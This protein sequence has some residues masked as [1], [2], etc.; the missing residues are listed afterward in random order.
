MKIH[1]ALKET[2]YLTDGLS[3]TGFAAIATTIGNYLLATNPGW[4]GRIPCP[5]ASPARPTRAGGTT[6]IPLDGFRFQREWSSLGQDEFRLVQ[7][8]A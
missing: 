4:K 6:R 3:L 5:P 1:H 8:F 7:L 2:S